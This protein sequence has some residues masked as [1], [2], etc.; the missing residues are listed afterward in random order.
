VFLIVHQ[1][2]GEFEGR[3]QLKT[4]I[5][6]VTY[7]VAQNYRRRLRL[8]SHE[9]FTDATLCSRPSPAERLADDQAAQFVQEFCA[10][11]SENKR[12]IFVLCVLEERAGPEVAA[13]LGLNL[14]TVYSRARSAREEFRQA[15]G[16]LSQREERFR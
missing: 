1:K 4:W 2:L 7:R 10:R 15:L 3:A 13:I 12:D 11:L 9:P 8:R 14:N 5:Y 16:R 6:A